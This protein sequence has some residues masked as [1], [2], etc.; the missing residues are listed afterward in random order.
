MIELAV[1][2][3]RGRCTIVAGVGSNDTRHAVRLTE[4]ATALGPRR[5]AVGQ[6][7]LQ[8]SQPPRDHRPLPG[9]GAGHRP[10]DPALQH[11][12]A[13]R[14][15]TCPTTCSP[16]S[17]SS[18]TSSASSRPT[19]PTWPRSTGWSSTPATTT[20][21]PTCSTSASPAG[22]SP[23][24]TCSARRCA[25]WSTSPSTGAR[26]TPASQDV[27]RDL[28]IAPLAC[29]I[30]AAL[31]LIGIPVG[32]PRASLRRARR[33]TSSRSSAACSSATAC[34]PPRLDDRVTA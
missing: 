24:A 11:P 21:S 34:S 22:S 29:S 31:N 14:R 8:P 30:K 33:R 16:S 9:G 12:P 1:S 7:V 6:P 23:A 20:C 27:Y 10:A 2:E 26:S 19:R 3:M 28:A 18:T 5:A 13:D 4:R 15:R 25:G 32:A 17:A